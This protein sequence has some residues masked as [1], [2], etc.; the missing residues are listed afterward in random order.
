M[1]V[2]IITINLNN[3]AGLRKTII[4]VV[5]QSYTDYEYIIID[6][7]S[8]DGS[9]DVIKEFEDKIA[10]WISEPDKGIYNAMNKGIKLSIGEYLLFLNSGDCL[11]DDSILINVFGVT[12]KADILYGNINA[13]LP[14]GTKKVGIPLSG[15]KLTLLN[16]ISNE[17]P[18]IQQPASFIK[19]TLFNSGFFD[20][21]YRIIADIKFFIERIIFQNRSTEYLPLVITDF[22]TDGLSSSPSNWSAT[23]E[24]RHRIFKELLPPLIYKD[25]QL[26]FQIKD[27][28]LL[29][30][31]PLLERTDRLNKFV[32]FLVRLSL[33]THTFLR[34]FL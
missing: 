31:I 24:E 29:K 5:N 19:K 21:S 15:E 12:R 10:Y 13:I 2:S 33:K 23:I 7:G 1:K 3:Q 22:T 18:T 25:Y 14:D 20:E 6:G 8:N 26:F 28:Q 34:R 32:T 30:Y 11:T 27:S 16:F 17:H 9:I 4:S